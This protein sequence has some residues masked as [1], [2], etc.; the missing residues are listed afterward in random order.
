[1]QTTQKTK[2]QIVKSILIIF[3][4][5]IVLFNFVEYDNW[6]D[7]KEASTIMFKKW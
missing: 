5:I 3:Y 4:P 1:M 2:E 6:N 7:F